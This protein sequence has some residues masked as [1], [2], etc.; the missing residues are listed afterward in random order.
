MKRRT[1]D[2]AQD[3]A[4]PIPPATDWNGFRNLIRNHNNVTWRN[5]D[6]TTVPHSATIDFQVTGAPDRR[7]VFDLEIIQRCLKAGLQY[8][9]SKE[10]SVARH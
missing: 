9:I 1:L 8:T 2:H 4:P 10:S 3:P 5:F 7:R 6:V